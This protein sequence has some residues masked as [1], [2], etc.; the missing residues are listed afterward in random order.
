MDALQLEL[1]KLRRDANLSQSIQ[2]V[3]KIIAQL[4]N[5]R[6]SIVLGMET[7]PS[8]CGV[9]DDRLECDRSIPP[10]ALFCMNFY[11]GTLT[12]IASTS[13]I[14]IRLLS[15][16]RNFKIPSRAVS[17]RSMTISRRYTKAIAIMGKLWIRYASERTSCIL[18][19]TNAVSSTSQSKLC[20][21]STMP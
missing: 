1:A 6:E 17:T 9:A 16:L 21:L 15:R 8:S 5:A 7:F 3:D 2:D 14:L 18:A 12:Y 13:Q 4:E 20:L 10:L 11:S 19:Y